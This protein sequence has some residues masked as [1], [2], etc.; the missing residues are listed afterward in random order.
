MEKTKTANVPAKELE[1][2]VKRLRKDDATEILIK[3]NSDG[4]FNV[5]ASFPN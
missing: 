4:T 2:T 3:K 5:E 1:K